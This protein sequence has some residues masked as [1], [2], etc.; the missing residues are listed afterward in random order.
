MGAGLAGALMANYS[1]FVSPDMLH[2]TQSG[3]LMIMIILGG[4]GTL[5]GPA[6]GRRRADRARDAARRLDRALA[7]HPGSDPDR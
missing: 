3:D 7:V 2:W 6:L 4:T 1:R 5:L